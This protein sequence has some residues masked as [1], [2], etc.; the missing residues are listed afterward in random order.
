MKRMLLF[1]AMVSL[2]FSAQAQL[3]KSS[4]NQSKE[5]AQ[6][7]RQVAQAKC[8]PVGV[9]EF[10]KLITQKDIVLM[11]VRTPKEYAEGHLKGAVNVTWGDEFEK[12]V[13]GVKIGAKKTVAVYCR[14]GRRS[15][16]AAEMLVKMGYDV[17]ELDGGIMAWE[18]AGKP[19]VK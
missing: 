19:V 9:E 1:A 16:A 11:D 4:A 3:T 10:A 15:H 5:K 12:Q 18:R 2:L 17:V 6:C 7:S 13:K 8:R 14:R